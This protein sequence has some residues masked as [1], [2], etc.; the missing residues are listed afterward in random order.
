MSG[1][2]SLLRIKTGRNVRW[3]CGSPEREDARQ[4]D[5]CVALPLD[6]E[7]DSVDERLAGGALGLLRARFA[8]GDTQRRR[9]RV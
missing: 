7:G 2:V 5:V 8:T 4:A 3:R 6:A 1:W 9:S